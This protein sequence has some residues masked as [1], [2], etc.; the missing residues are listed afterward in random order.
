VG[1]EEN[2]ALAACAKFKGNVLVIESERDDYV[3]HS[4]IANYVSAFREARSMTYR[5]ISGADHALTDPSCRR[6]YT[7]LLV[8][9]AREMVLGAR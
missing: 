4:T 3:P 2:R 1:V 5:V 8:G 9:W 6:A 7:S